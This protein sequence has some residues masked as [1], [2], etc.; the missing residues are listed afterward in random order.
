MFRIHEW[1]QSETSLDAETSLSRKSDGVVMA[2]IL[3]KKSHG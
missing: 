1:E 2:Y 3:T